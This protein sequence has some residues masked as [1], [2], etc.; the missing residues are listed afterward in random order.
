MVPDWRAQAPPLATLKMAADALGA[1]DR[2][3]A[4]RFET[5]DGG[6]RRLRAQRDQA[7]A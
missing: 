5:T 1:G 3:R 7:V 2:S 6:K 4:Q